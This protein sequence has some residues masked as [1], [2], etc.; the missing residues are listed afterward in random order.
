MSKCGACS[1]KLSRGE[2]LIDCSTC[3]TNYHILCVGITIQ[4]YTRLTNDIKRNWVCPECKSKIKKG[5]DNSD[6]PVKTLPK[7]IIDNRILKAVEST[8]SLSLVSESTN[9]DQ[10]AAL[11]VMASK[12]LVIH[13]QLNELITLQSDVKLI[14]E[15]LTLIKESINNRLESVSDRV[16]KLEDQLNSLKEVTKTVVDLGH[17]FDKITEESNS[18]DQW[19]RRSNIELIGIPEKKNENLIDLIKKLGQISGFL[20]DPQMDIDFVTRV[21]PRDY[22]GKQ[23]RPIVLKM[24][25][26]YRKDDFVSALRR[27]KLTTGDL[28]YDGCD[29]NKV[30][31]NDHLTSRNKYL[32]RQAKAI[33]K[34]KGFK[35]V[36][37]RNC[38]IIV[39]RND[40][41]SPIYIK[42][43]DDLNKIK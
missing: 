37:V 33:A 17:D 4:T 39:R 30:F 36:W 34:E 16:T 28:G 12:L 9:T 19:T 21:A 32:L 22:N 15:E 43:A 20:V 13:D 10:S 42:T 11:N 29:N 26:R 3:K 24:I 18:R 25:S 38:N 35:W 1:T 8:D 23:L 6:T 2:N 41:S 27:A 5:G 7:D 40:S 31:V 14:R